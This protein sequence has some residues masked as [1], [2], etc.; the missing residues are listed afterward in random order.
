MR[1]KGAKLGEGCPRV[2]LG[3]DRLP[4]RAHL[5][6]FRHGSG[7]RWGVAEIKDINLPG[8]HVLWPVL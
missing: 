8:P 2:R 3:Q 6:D 5:A 7:N 1:G 4:N